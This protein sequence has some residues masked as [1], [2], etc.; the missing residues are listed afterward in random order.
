LLQIK[1]QN[2]PNWLALPKDIWNIIIPRVAKQGYAIFS[3]Y[4]DNNFRK[5]MVDKLKR[6]KGI[7][8]LSLTCRLLHTLTQEYANKQ[9]KG[10][11]EDF[12]KAEVKLEA[13]LFDAVTEVLGSAVANICLKL[14]ADINAPIYRVDGRY[15]EYLPGGNETLLTWGLK[16]KEY[17]HYVPRRALK[18]GADPLCPN[19]LGE[20]PLDVAKKH[21]RWEQ[22]PMLEE[23]CK[24]ERIQRKKEKARKELL[25]IL[26]DIKN[27]SEK[28]IY[29]D[30]ASAKNKTKPSSLFSLKNSW[31]RYLGIGAG[32]LCIALIYN[33]WKESQS[34]ENDENNDDDIFIYGNH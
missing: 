7:K 20:L 28:K 16:N 2:N 1:F 3:D 14:G 18:F 9:L 15:F 31:M 12:N 11:Q 33:K 25:K 32:I 30:R 4:G 8:N 5:P 24:K 26:H 21:R 10:I 29:N 6:I 17:S 23:Y 13:L 27:Q 34:I 22:V 19:T